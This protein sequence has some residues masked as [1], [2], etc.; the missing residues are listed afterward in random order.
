MASGKNGKVHIHGTGIDVIGKPL[1]VN[2][3]VAALVAWDGGEIDA[4]GAAYNLSASGC[5]A[6]NP[7]KCSKIHRIHNSSTPTTPGHIHAPYLWEEHPTPPVNAGSSTNIPGN[8]L[9]SQDGADIAIETNCTATGCGGTQN[10]TESHF[11]IY[12]STCNTT[13]STNTNGPWW[14]VIAKKCRQ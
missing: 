8:V 9:F 10:G 5:T 13:P 1:V 6:D 2:V 12:K 3:D 4:N 14:D 7:P 11:L